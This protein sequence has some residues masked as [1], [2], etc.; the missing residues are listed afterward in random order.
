MYL[1]HV[2]ESGDNADVYERPAHPYAQA[3]LSAAPVPDPV[4]ERARRRIVLTGDV[5][6]PEV[7]PPLVDPGLGHPVACH[8]PEVA[9]P[10]SMSAAE[11]GVP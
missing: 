7:E 10:F 3:L 11:G 8:L 1:G 2:V 5:P 6:N 4:P 9:A